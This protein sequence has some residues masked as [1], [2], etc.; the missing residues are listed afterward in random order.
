MGIPAVLLD[1]QDVLADVQQISDA[2]GCALFRSNATDSMVRSKDPAGEV[3]VAVKSPA[4]AKGKLERASIV[5]VSLT[6]L[7]AGTFQRGRSKETLFVA[8]AIT[9]NDEKI[10]PDMTSIPISCFPA[11]VRFS[12]IMHHVSRDT[13]C[14]HVSYLPISSLAITQ[15]QEEESEQAR[16]GS[17][18]VPAS[19]VSHRVDVNQHEDETEG[20]QQ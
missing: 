11:I 5:I 4:C 19:R 7:K 14:F 1:V 8:T 20:K 15:C 13:T 17:I 16:H 12:A 2:G 3:I 9:K 18:P 6:N 10:T